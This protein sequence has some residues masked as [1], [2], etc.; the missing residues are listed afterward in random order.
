MK[1]IIKLIEKRIK[2]LKEGRST[3]TTSFTK[4]KYNFA[5]GELQNLIM[6]IE[7]EKGEKK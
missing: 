1:K 7:D 3:L 2:E 4:T 6:D 5:I